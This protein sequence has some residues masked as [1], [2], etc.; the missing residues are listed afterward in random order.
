MWDLKAYR[1]K[2]CRNSEAK[3]KVGILMLKKVK[4]SIGKESAGVL[5]LRLCLVTT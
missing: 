4:N 1:F 5:R 3:G 2:L